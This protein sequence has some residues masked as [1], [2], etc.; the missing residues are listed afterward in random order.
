MKKIKIIISILTVTIFCGCTVK[1]NIN[2]SD[3]NITEEINITEKKNLI[4]EDLDNSFNEDIYSQYNSKGIKLYTKSKSNNGITN[5]YTLKQ[6]YAILN[7]KK[8]RALNECFDAVNIVKDEENENRYL[9]QTSKGFKCM[10]YDY[11][12]ISSYEINI[13]TDYD[14]IDHNADSYKNNVYTWN[15][16]NDNA[17]QKTIMLEFQKKSTKQKNKNKFN[18]NYEMIAIIIGIIFVAFLIGLGIIKSIS[19]KNNKI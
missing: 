12:P 13:T 18:I 1:Y 16:N 4:T 14:V 17:D 15:I 8:A 6:N 19:N 7:Y 11:A 10:T 9:F 3:D 2:I 5:T